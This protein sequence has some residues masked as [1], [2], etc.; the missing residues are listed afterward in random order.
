MPLGLFL[1]SLPWP[2]LDI[3]VKVVGFLGATLIIYAVLLEEEKRQDAV[4]V[5]GSTALLV[6]SLVYGNTVFS[7]LS[8]GVLLVS[9]RELILIVGGKHH[10]SEKLVQEYK[11]PEQK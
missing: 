8:A 10:H 2:T 7:F 1:P 5:V 6:Y 3:L 4:F 9:A 11:H